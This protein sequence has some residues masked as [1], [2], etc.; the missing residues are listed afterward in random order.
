MFC[1]GMVLLPDGRALING[2]TIQYDPFYGALASSIFD[3]STN[4]FST[5]P[6]MAHGRWYPT[7]LTLGDGQ[8]MTFSGTNERA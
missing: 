4:T 6:N 7:L 2:G 1:N 8:I 5:V 3:P